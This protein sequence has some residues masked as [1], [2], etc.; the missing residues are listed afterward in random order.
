MRCPGCN[1]DLQA[2]EDQGLQLQN[3]PQ[4]HRVW[5]DREGLDQLINRFKSEELPA[6]RIAGGGF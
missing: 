2:C 5:L 4:C 3:C 1:A 6:Y